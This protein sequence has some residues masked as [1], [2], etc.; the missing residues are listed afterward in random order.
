MQKNEI[1]LDTSR[2]CTGM[3]V[4]N[5][6][7]MCDLLGQKV[8]TGNSKKAQLELWRRYFDW[9]NEGQKFLILDVYKEP[10]AGMLPDNAAYAKFMQLSLMEAACGVESGIY[11]FFPVWLMERVGMVNDEYRELVSSDVNREAMFGPGGTRDESISVLGADAITNIVHNRLLRILDDA[12]KCMDRNAIIHYKKEYCVKETP[13][14][15]R[16]GFRSAT[17]EEEKMIIGV[18]QRVLS[19]FRITDK[20]FA[21]STLKDPFIKKVNH[22]IHLERQD[23]YGATR[24][25][26]IIYRRPCVSYYNRVVSKVIKDLKKKGFDINE[27]EYLKREILDAS[28]LA[29]NKLVAEAL[30][31]QAH[32]EIAKAAKNVGKKYYGDDV[33]F[34]ILSNS[35][36]GDFTKMINKYVKLNM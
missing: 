20:W 34:Y 22:Y 33:L 15:I 36:M 2:L 28:K 26:E 21:Y 27:E 23:L 30:D 31:K 6:A 32:R 35:F 3:V 18:E 1:E 17:K 24:W 7:E 13:W 29:L 11:H 5:Y 8:T 12:L 9:E 4:K 25:I 10:I 19:E 14:E 16:G